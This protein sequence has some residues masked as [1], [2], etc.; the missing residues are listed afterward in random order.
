MPMSLYTG[1]GYIQ[2]KVMQNVEVGRSFGVVDVGVAYGRISQRPDSTGFLEGKI[3][4]DACQ[5]G[6]FSNEFTIGFGGVF[7]STTPIMLEISYTV[8]AQLG[9]HWGLGIV[10]GYI[11]FSGNTHDSAKN[12]FGLF[13]RFGL[14]R[15]DGGILMNRRVRG[16]HGK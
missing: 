4:M 16:H 11:D 12:Y 6:M 2:D 13:A 7:H 14:Q 9:K 3:T 8:F 10:T 15:S 5:Y 1:S